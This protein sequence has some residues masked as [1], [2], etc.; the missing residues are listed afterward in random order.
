MVVLVEEVEEAGAGN[1]AVEKEQE[2]VLGVVIAHAGLNPRALSLRA[3]SQPNRHFV[4][5]RRGGMYSGDP[6]SVHICT[7]DQGRR[8]CNT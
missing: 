7:D 3:E 2:E 8:V 4:N 1:E 6:S 5:G